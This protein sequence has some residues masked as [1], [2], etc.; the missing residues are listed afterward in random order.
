MPHPKTVE[1]MTECAGP[2]ECD[3]LPKLIQVTEAAAIAAAYQMGRG[4][5]NFADQVAVAAMRRMLNKLD[6]KGIIK[7]GEGERDEAPMLFI[8]EEVGT[9]KGVEVDIAVDPLEGTNLTADGCPG[10][11]AV[12]AMAERGGIFHG[13]DIYI[14]KIVV[15]PDV[16][17]YENEHPYEKIDLDAPVRRNLEIVA[18]ALGRSIKEIVV[19][20]LDRPRHAQKITEIREAGARVRLVSD[21]D[22]MPGVATGIRGSGIHVVMGAGGSGEAVLTAAAT[23]ALGGK[24]IGRLVLPSVANGMPREKIDAEIEEKLPRLEKMGITLE[25]LNEIMDTD[26]LVPGKDVIFSATAVTPGHFLHEVSLF[27]SGDARVHTI[28][29]GSSGAVKFTDSIYIKDKQKNPLYL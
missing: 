13:P 28:S 18:K 22:L 9:G 24:I 20:I 11:V 27:G 15:G 12:M 29:M 5:K 26:K 25:S 19:V 3:V 21:G 4:D 7:I 16:V 1:E 10:S 14:D 2:I 6:I 8:G 23:K 17:K